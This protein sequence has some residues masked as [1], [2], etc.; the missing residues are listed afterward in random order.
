MKLTNISET[1]IHIWDGSQETRRKEVN[2]VALF[3][4]RVLWKT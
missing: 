3:Q 1:P 4:D 2:S